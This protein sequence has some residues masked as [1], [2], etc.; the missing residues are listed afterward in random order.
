MTLQVLVSETR[1]ASKFLDYVGVVFSDVEKDLTTELQKALIPS[2]REATKE[3]EQATAE[4]VAN[5]YDSEYAKA[6]IA[7]SSCVDDPK[8]PAKIAAAKVAMWSANQK[9]QLAGLYGSFADGD[10]RHFAS[11]HGRCR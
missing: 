9:A 5:E 11:A 1:S 4:R 7:L 2:V 6:L 10:K 8:D 3:T